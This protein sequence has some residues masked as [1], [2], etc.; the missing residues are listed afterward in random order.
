[1]RLAL[2]LVVIALVRVAYLLGAGLDLSPDEAYYWSWSQHLDLGYYSKP[3]L[4][5]WI[6]A[7]TT[8][9]LGNH[10]WAVRLP[11]VLLGTGTLALLWATTRQL[12]GPK[13]AWISLLLL[14]ATPANVA[15]NFLMTIDS[16]LAFGWALALWAM[17][18]VHG[19]SGEL[20]QGLCPSPGKRDLMGWWN[21]AG[22]GLI[23]ALLA[24][25]MGVILLALSV[26]SWLTLRQRPSGYWQRWPVLVVATLVALAAPL[27]W[28]IANGFITLRH[29]SEHFETQA[30][31]TLLGGLGTLLDF[32][33]SQFALLNPV[34]AIVLTALI[35]VGLRRFPALADRERFLFVWG[36]L[37]LLLFVVLALWQRVHPNWPLVFYLPCF[38]LLGGFFAGQIPGWAP[39][40][41]RGWCRPAL[42]TGFIMAGLVM[43]F[44]AAF[45]ALD[46]AGTR[47]DA[48]HRLRGW[49]ELAAQVQSVRTEWPGGLDAPMVAYSPRHPVDALTFYLPDHPRIYRWSRSGI[50]TQHELWPGPQR[51][52]GQSVLVLSDSPLE[53]GGPEAD[54]FRAC[55]E[56]LDPIDSVAIRIGPDRSRRYWLYTGVNLRDWQDLGR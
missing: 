6:N 52:F 10:T 39:R 46:L 42:A 38:V 24:K 20:P 3:P 26:L 32:L 55:F 12:Y 14:L 35:A 16:P 11:A 45:P 53:D 25:Q 2:L 4:I 56:R 18:R 28:N 43:A 37:P 13:A 34:T 40:R 19:R 44:P 51:S 1:M 7:A 29:T 27:A 33:A 50:A 8:G 23:I 54:A 41:F 30:T 17:V 9:L 15:M 22:I 31:W 21:L 5:A 48:Y 47:L 49:R 36:P